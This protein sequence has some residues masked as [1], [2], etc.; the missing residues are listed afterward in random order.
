MALSFDVSKV[1]NHEVVTTATAADG[2]TI[3]HP[4]TDGLIW[5]SLT[6]GIPSITE[7]NAD[8]VIE[9]IR[10]IEEV[11]GAMRVG[12]NLKGLYF[13]AEEIRAHIGLV[14]NASRKTRVEF[15]KGIMRRVEEKARD[16]ARFRAIDIARRHITEGNRTKAEAHLV[17]EGFHSPMAAMKVVDDLIAEMGK[18]TP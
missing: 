2:R 10:I 11:F 1:K 18:V 17:S 5:L 16:G 8:E 9:R 12:E 4:A 3:W 15:S 13:T 14:T 6:T 7:K